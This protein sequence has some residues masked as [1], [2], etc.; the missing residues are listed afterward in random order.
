MNQPSPNLAAIE[1]I[2]DVAQL[3]EMLSRPTAGVIE[4]MG[5]LEGDLIF[6]GAGGKIGPSLA[7]MA[8]RARDAAGVKRRVIGVVRTARPDV[9]LSFQAHGVELIECDLLD[10]E[11]LA[12][13][14]EVPNVVYLAAMKF[15]S[16]GAEAY[17][18][19]LNSYLPG[20]VCERFHASRIVA[21]STGNVYR[22]APIHSGGST[23]DSPLE[24]VG[25]YAMSCLGRERIFSYFS[26]C[27]GLPVALIRLNYAHEMRYGVIVDI[28]QKVMAGEP[29]DLTMGYFNAIWQGDANA[30]TLRALEQA[31][32]PA[33]PINMTG[34]DT[35][36]V[37]DVAKRFGQLLERP[38]TFTGSE[39]A[40]ALLSNGSLGYELLGRP[41]VSP[42]QMIRWIA[43]WQQRGRPV[44]GKPTR[45]QVRDG[46]F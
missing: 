7:R 9:V 37:R 40:D 5:R 41:E 30:M 13:L 36:H 39:A 11:Q 35:L 18:W 10:R 21:Y 38:V 16:T 4:A 46:K 32:A 44:L 31:A 29:I 12:A 2:E 25:D 23:E 34:P 24:P 1:A 3:E 19:A 6:L 45:F 33:R 27:F 22:M 26:E 15:G 8:R 28:A 14:P 42:E 43:D 17:T 20:L